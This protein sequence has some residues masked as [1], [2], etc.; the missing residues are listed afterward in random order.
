MVGISD[1]QGAGPHPWVRDRIPDGPRQSYLLHK[2][3]PRSQKYPYA[4]EMIDCR[5]EVSQMRQIIQPLFPI[6]KI[7]SPTSLMTM[8]MAWPSYKLWHHS[9]WYVFMRLLSPCFMMSSNKNS[10]LIEA[11]AARTIRSSNSF[12]H[13]LLCLERRDHAGIM[14]DKE[15]VDAPPCHCGLILRQSHA[16]SLASADFSCSKKPSGLVF[17]SNNSSRVFIGYYFQS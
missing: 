8:M 17:L 4:F 1:T 13:G 3:T 6:S 16:R 15:A 9:T 14:V 12:W 10:H 11:V 5:T 7:L 2:F